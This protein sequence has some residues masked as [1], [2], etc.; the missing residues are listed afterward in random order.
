MQRPVIAC[1][2]DDVLMHFYAGFVPYH[3]ALHGS[4]VQYE[5]IF[6]YDMTVIWKCDDPTIVQR[7]T[8]FVHSPFHA[9][10]MP[11]PG[12][13]EA[14]LHLRNNYTLDIVTSRSEA[15]RECTHLWAKNAFADSFR[16]LHFTNGF[17]AK[18]GTLKRHKSEVCMEIGASVLI[19]DAL[20]H[21]HDVAEKGIPVLLPDRPWNRSET[22]PGVTRVRSW[23]EITSWIEANI[24]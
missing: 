6:T 18:E 22:P 23:D 1:D 12:S 14:I 24:H 3:N 4:N 13:V 20:K 21:A 19:E 8:D 15:F 16:D 9:D 2:F 11:I 5:D 10:V 7:V 17:G